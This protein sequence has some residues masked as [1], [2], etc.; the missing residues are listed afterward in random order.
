MVSS[1]K[2][3]TMFYSSLDPSMYFMVGS[4]FLVEEIENLS[5]E[6]QSWYDD[7]STV[8][9]RFT[10]PHSSPLFFPSFQDNQSSLTPQ[11]FSSCI[12]SRWWS[13]KSLV[14]ACMPGWKSYSPS[15]SS[16]VFY[17]SLFTYYPW[18]GTDVYF[19]QSTLVMPSQRSEEPQFVS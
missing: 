13:L 12:T 11:P 17:L 5:T 4:Q 16:P 19:P 14:S 6:K 7:Y 1:L 9:T 15:V 8:N 3:E 10:S 18:C 2:A